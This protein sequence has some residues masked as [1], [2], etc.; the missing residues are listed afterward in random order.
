MKKYLLP[1]L[2]FVFI[3]TSCEVTVGGEN[4]KDEK[5]NNEIKNGFSYESFVVKING[6]ESINNNEIIRGENIF[7]EFDGVENATLKDEFQHV[8]ISLRIYN[9]SGELVDEY[10]DLLSKIEQQDPKIDFFEA[11]FTVPLDEKEESMTM[12]VTL[13]DK[14]GTIS[15]DFKETYTLVSK[16][17]LGTKGVEIKTKLEGLELSSQLFQ[18]KRQLEKT[19]A[20]INKEDEV[21]IFLNGVKGFT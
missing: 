8:G 13:F 15:Y 1:I 14:Y 3:A 10:D 18:I 4:D 2:S 16:I 19:P 20:K 12:E 6:V 11:F 7:V 5:E 17:P 21:L 9:T